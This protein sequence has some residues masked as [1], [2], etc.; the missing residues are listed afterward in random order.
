MEATINIL[1]SSSPKVRERHTAGT[2]HR[3]SQTGHDI[4]GP[5]PS[6][7]YSSRC[8][9]TW[10][11]HCY[12]RKSSIIYIHDSALLLTRSSGRMGHKK[13][14]PKIFQV[15]RCT[16]GARH[17]S[18]SASQDLWSLSAQVPAEANERSPILPRCL[19]PLPPSS[20]TYVSV[21][22]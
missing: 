16:E 4:E 14:C 11:Q 12:S 2:S 22:P 1:C 6:V 10:H 17:A 5:E 9:V 18:P 3:C 7:W 19:P 8:Y 21:G 20:D 13:G 15:Q